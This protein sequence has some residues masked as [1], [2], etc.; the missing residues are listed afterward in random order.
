MWRK[1]RLCQE[2]QAG[3]T[4]N[5]WMM[6]VRG[7]CTGTAVALIITVLAMCPSPAGADP[8]RSKIVV[9]QANTAVPAATQ[10][11]PAVANAPGMAPNGAAVPGGPGGGGSYSYDPSGRRDP[12]SALIQ[13]KEKGETDTTL[14]PLQR[15]GLTEINLIGIIWGGF[16]YTGMVQTPDG[17]GY[18]VRRGTRIGP[19][20]GVVTK[21][22]K[23]GIVVTERY[24]DIYG[25]EEEREHVK[26]LHTSEESE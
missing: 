25:K 1:T 6:S 5:G 24:T 11:S 3:R 10:A 12:F 13:G 20:N 23:N 18:S 8:A 14:P 9:A 15:V 19:N 22:T 2:A 17:K 26:L 7:W 21:I 16:G 4:L